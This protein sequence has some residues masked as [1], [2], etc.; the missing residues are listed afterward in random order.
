MDTAIEI[1]DPYNQDTAKVGMLQNDLIHLTEFGHQTVYNKLNTALGFTGSTT[2]TGTTSSGVLAVVSTTDKASEIIV[3]GNTIS[4]NT[5]AWKSVRGTIGKSSGKWYWEVKNETTS[6]KY[7]VRGIGKST[8]TLTDRVGI[9]TNGNAWYNDGSS[10]LR[11]TGNS[12]VN[13]GGLS[14]SGDIIG[15]A[16]DM[17]AGTLTAYKNGVSQGVMYS[18]LS[19]TYFPMFSVY[20]A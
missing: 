16:L 1:V 7:W 4:S 5:N 17:D 10:S 14:L 18:G 11:Y 19:G 6:N 15:Y 20:G 9:D 3:T 13:Y 12:P 2:S 8:A